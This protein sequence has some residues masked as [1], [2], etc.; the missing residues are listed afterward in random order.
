MPAVDD[1]VARQREKERAERY[2]ARQKERAKEKA[3]EQRRQF[4]LDKPTPSKQVGWGL[5]A[6]SRMERL[7]YAQVCAILGWQVCATRLTDLQ[8]DRQVRVELDCK[9]CDVI[10][11][12]ISAREP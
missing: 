9:L 12:R 1:G 2:E 10:F 7:L 8:F 3:A 6:L 5:H 11:P 4:S